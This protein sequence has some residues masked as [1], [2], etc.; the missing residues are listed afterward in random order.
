VSPEEVFVNDLSFLKEIPDPVAS[1][2]QLAPPSTPRFASASP[3]RSGTQRSRLLAAAVS[4]LWLAAHLGAYGLREDLQRLPPSYLL[5]Q[6]GL[7]ALLGAASLWLALAPGKLGLGVSISL[8]SGLAVLGPLSFWLMAAGVPAPYAQGPAE[9][10]WLGSLLCMDIT[11]AWAAVPLLLAALV[12]RR[13]FP[14]ATLWRSAL[15]GA[16]VGL[17]CGAAINLHCANV[18]PS[19]LLAGHGTPIVLATLLGGMVVSRWTRA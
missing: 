16:A 17:F 3:V 8:V 18:H 19:H 4:V 13:A 5:L 11:L 10:F 9:N 1:A 6:A 12:L 2:P 15:V 14:S 7:P